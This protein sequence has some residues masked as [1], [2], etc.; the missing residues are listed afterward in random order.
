MDF[1]SKYLAVFH[2]QNAFRFP[3]INFSQPK[4][5]FIK[6][7]R[8]QWFFAARA[9]ESKRLDC[10]HARRV[11]KRAKTRSHTRER[12]RG[13]SLRPRGCNREQ[14]RTLK[15]QLSPAIRHRKCKNKNA[16]ALSK[17]INKLI[18]CPLK[19]AI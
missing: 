7:R 5:E 3:S 18:D 4:G 17:N 10:N 8:N 19:C 15:P 1:S 14:P 16:I 12:E 11:E 6:P 9:W 2:N 13:L